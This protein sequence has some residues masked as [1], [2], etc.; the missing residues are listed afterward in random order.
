MEALAA[1]EDR[2]ACLLGNHGVI[3]LGKT[4]AKAFAVLEE[5]EN[6]ARVYIGTRLLGGGVILGQED[7]TVVLER[8][9]SYGKQA[10]E[11]IDP[12]LKNKVEPPPYGGPKRL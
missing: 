5:I 11:A 8:F 10:G 2:M 12:T 7:M 6:L 3:A 4:P 9:K 1:L